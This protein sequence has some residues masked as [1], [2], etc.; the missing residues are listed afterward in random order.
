MLKQFYE[1]T[2]PSQGFYCVTSIKDDV[3]RNRFAESL[4]EVVDLIETLNET[5]HNVFVAL[6]SF[7]NYSRAGKNAIYARSFYIDLDVDPENPRKYAS[8]DAALEDL[9]TFLSI[10]K[11]PPP[12]RVDSGNGIHAYWLFDQDIAIPEWKRYVEKF[13]SLCNDHI[14]IDNNVTGDVARILRCPET[15][16]Y[17]TDPPRPTSFIDT[18]FGQYSFQQFKE[19]LGEEQS[20]EEILASIE[21]DLPPKEDNFEYVFERKH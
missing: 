9:D 17:K 19:F 2:L 18:D 16:N 11:L 15:N 10:V 7:A 5:Q 1:K 4:D 20:V 13:K 6:S 14:K 21:P 3:V 12:I 8:K